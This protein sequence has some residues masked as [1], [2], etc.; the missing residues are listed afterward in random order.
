M[1]VEPIRAYMSQFWKSASCNGEYDWDY[2]I[3]HTLKGFSF[4]RQELAFYMW[5]SFHITRYINRMC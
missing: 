1:G 2:S 5:L 3:R 4:N